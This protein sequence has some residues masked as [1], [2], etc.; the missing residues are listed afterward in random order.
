MGW[1]PAVA[2]SG[3]SGPDTVAFMNLEGRT[4]GR[5]IA[6]RLVREGS[7]VAVNYCQRSTEAENDVAFIHQQSG[8][9]LAVQTDVGT[10]RRRRLRPNG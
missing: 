3:P 9:A 5:A 2:R 7:A 10:L 8:R 4:I 6:L 1:R